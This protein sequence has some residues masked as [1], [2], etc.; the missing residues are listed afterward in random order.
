MAKEKEAK[1]FSYKVAEKYIRD[2]VYKPGDTIELTEEEAKIPIDLG[3]LL[4]KEAS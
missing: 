1:K 4:P 2:K 3:I